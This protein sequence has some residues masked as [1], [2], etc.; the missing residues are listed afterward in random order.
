MTPIVL[1][2]LRMTFPSGVRALE[3]ITL[4]IAAGEWC[5]VLGPSGCGKTTLLRIIA[6]LEMPT[7][8]AVLLDGR[9]ARGI[10]PHHRRVALARQ[11]PAL[12]PNRS[13]EQNLRFPHNPDP[14]RLEAVVE[15]LSLGSILRSEPG[16][17]SGGQR[18]RVSLAR[19]LLRSASI[20]LLDEPLAQLDLSARL[21]IRERLP[22]LLGTPTPTIVHVT[23]DTD[24]ALHLA[25]RVVLLEGGRLLGTGSVAEMLQNHGSFV[26]GR[27]NLP[28]S[29]GR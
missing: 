8:G 21:E 26:V 9:N 10:A 24:E 1:D 2:R 12:Y 4:S 7:S 6:G 18:Q 17:L 15:G 19:A 5:C 22:L 14:V 13:V 28:P 29:D 23:H 11:E 25:D 27:G 16:K 3:E 20:L